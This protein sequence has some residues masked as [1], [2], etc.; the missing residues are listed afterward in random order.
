VAALLSGD[1]DVVGVA[2]DGTEAIDKAGQVHPDLIV[3]DVEMPGLDGFQTIRALRRGGFSA[4]PVVFLSMHDGD[5]VVSEAF[6]CDGCGYV[7]KHRVGRDLKNAL[8]Q[9][10]LGRSFVPSL[11]PLVS[12]DG[13]SHVMHLYDDV[14]SFVD[15]LATC[16]DLALRRGDATCVIATTPVRERLRDRLR[17]RG[18]DVGRASGHKRYLA[19]DAADALGRFMRNGLPDPGRLAE[20]ARELDEYRRAESEGPT[21]RLTVFGNMVVSLS[22]HGNTPAMLALESHWNRLTHDLPFLTVCGY[23]SSCFHAGVPGLWSNVCTERKALSHAHDVSPR[24]R[25]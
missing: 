8:D 4:I 23:A 24:T 7:L 21:S 19:I 25:H 6:R 1:F 13:G 11:A 10:L 9:A 2:T 3:M 16:F 20:V 5:D 22:A 12:A 17:A 15:G 14:E 18:W